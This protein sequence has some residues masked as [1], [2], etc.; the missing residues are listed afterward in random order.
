MTGG[1]RR[2]P[3][4]GT[5]GLPDP[6]EVVVDIE[7][8]ELAQAPRLV[9]EVGDAF[10]RRSPVMLHRDRQHLEPG[11]PHLGVEGVDIDDP[12]VGRAAVVAGSRSGRAKKWSSTSPRS[13]IP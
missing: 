1:L 10:E 9:L 2:P 5:K 3:L 7:Q 12:N 8:G 11:G 13:R 6:Q 4:A